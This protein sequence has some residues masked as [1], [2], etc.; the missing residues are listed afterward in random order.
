MAVLSVKTEIAN[1]QTS[2]QEMILSQE[3]YGPD[4]KLAACEKTSLALRQQTSRTVTKRVTVE[5]P[6]LWDVESPAMYTCVSRLLSADGKECF[7]EDTVQFGI[8]TLAVDAK[9]GLRI[10]SK[11]VKLRGACI[12]HDSGLLGAAT[13]DDAHRRQVRI[14]KDAGFNAIRMSHHPAAPA[15]LRA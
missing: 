12:H 6:A 1:E 10:N 2:A 9:R 5:D 14:L 4:G 15:L 7:D 3:I 11:S 13:Y 8:R